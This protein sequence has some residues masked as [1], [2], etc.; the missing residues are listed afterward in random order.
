MLA[1][2]LY[3]SAEDLREQQIS[4]L[5]VLELFGSG[6]LYGWAK[7]YSWQPFPGLLLLLFGYIS[8]EQIGYGDGWL[9]LALGMWLDLSEL[10]WMLLIGMGL[11]GLSAFLLHKKELPLVPF[12]T[13][14]YMI[15]GKI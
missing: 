5:V 11:G 9:I 15:G 13:V 12:L 6:L 1:H 3:L 2:L 8:Q 10:L 4:I 7:G 14:A